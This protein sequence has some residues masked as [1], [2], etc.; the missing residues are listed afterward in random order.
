MVER[1]ENRFIQ[2]GG[3]PEG[4]DAHLIVDQV[5]RTNAPVL[6]VAREARRIRALKDALAFFAPD[7]PVF[8]FPAWDC[9]PYDRVS[10]NPDI[11][12][13]RM[14]TLAG[15]CANSKMACIILTTVNAVTQRLPARTYIEATRLH[16]KVGKHLSFDDLLETFS[17]MGFTRT[18]TV[19]ERGEFAV[20]GGIVDVFPSLG[21]NPLRLDLFGDVLESARVFDIDSQ[22]TLERTMQIDIAPVSEVPFDEG[23]L[24]R[25]RQAYRLAF[26]AATT[27]QD[28]LFDAVSEGRRYQGMEHWLPLFFDKMETL[29]DYL[30]AATVTLD[31]QTQD[32]REARWDSILDAYQARQLVQ[33]PKKTPTSFDTPIYRPLEPEKLYMTAQDWQK[34][35]QKHPVRQFNPNPQPPGMNV[36]DAA[37]RAGRSFAAERQKNENVFQ[38]LA[39]YIK[40]ERK[41]KKR[42][43]IASYSEGARDRLKGL[44]EE[45]NVVNVFLAD[46]WEN[47]G[48]KTSLVVWP[49]EE[50]FKTPDTV[51]ISEQDV[52]GERLVRRGKKKKSQNVLTEASTMSKGDLVVHVDHG[53]GRYMGLEAVEALG[54]PHDCLALE[55]ANE[56]RLYLPV[57]NIELLS[58]YGGN[59]EAQLDRMG[60]GA[61]QGRKAKL[62]NRI[63]DIADKLLKVAAERALKKGQ[64]I[65]PPDTAYDEFCAKF[66][67]EETE[68]QLNAIADVFSD[69]SSGQ[70]MDRL[71]CGDVGF[72]KTEVAIRAAFA[73]S[74]TGLQVALICP[75]T[76][77]SR[78]HFMDFEK[79]FSGLPVTVRQLSKFVTPKQA[80][81]TREG[82]KNGQVDIVIGTHALLAKNIDFKNLGLLII[83]EEQ[84]FGVTHKE[85]L[86]ELRADVHVLTMTATPIPRTLQLAM[87][88]VRELSLI[89]TPPVDRLAIRTY[90]AQFDPVM[91][92]EAL[93]R[94]HYRGGQAFYIVPRI[95]DIKEVSDFLTEFVPEVK[96]EIATGKL[97]PEEL[98]DKMN[99]FYDGKFDVLLATTIVESGLDIPTANTLIV[100]RAEMFGLSQLYQIR[101]RVGRSKV[102]AYAYITTPVRKKLTPVAEKRLRILGSLDELGAGFTLASHDLDIRGAGNLLGDE[103]SGHI[104]EVGYQLYQEMLQETIIKLRAEK[105]GKTDDNDDDDT[106]SPQIH[107]GVPV[108]IPESYIAD[109]DVRMSLYSRLSCLQ[110]HEEL[111]G[112]AAELHD[113]FGKPPVEVEM[114]L[115]VVRIKA[116][117]RRAGIAQID[118]GDKGCVL[119]F[120]HN[121][122][123]NPKGLMNFIHSEK[124]K[125]KLRSDHK[126]VVMRDW[127]KKKLRVK[128][129]FLIAKELAKIA[130]NM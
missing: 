107:L 79:R 59:G 57:E 10:P 58:R 3:A 103:Q 26:G 54:A 30:P 116:M 86:K 91:I 130:V 90:V 60:S 5:R 16:A 67:Y 29:F 24:A 115:R 8:V 22:R 126:L 44:L 11:S 119:T 98:D 94:E 55:Y 69:L 20:R 89:T 85:R 92:R 93:L 48:K 28:P 47:V 110:T 87:S 35:L 129:S 41:N 101:G 82:L 100:H 109:L 128:G 19:S 32:T 43:V 108:L 51:V 37:G 70:P 15:I 114:L 53:I 21:E 125:A 123:V 23:S 112:F 118:A 73:A 2:V 68:D 12:A 50:G 38:A 42:V 6:H 96:F 52:L 65:D 71:V 74:V 46:R 124:D 64:R 14:A 122:F 113:R 61:W 111:E 117:C 27:A 83:D 97:S 25:F 121:T 1:R 18:A 106:W 62:K 66:P 63:R 49:L 9:L 72:G 13:I 34:A 80:K 81:E 33:S 31:H 7:I 88:G 99:A 40:I 77:L 95:K 45:H 17:R 36:I 120:R 84:H 4:W 56:T 76:L 104:R 78:Q 39:D 75:T 105:T 102:R 127:K